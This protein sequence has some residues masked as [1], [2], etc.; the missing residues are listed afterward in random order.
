MV[1]TSTEAATPPAHRLKEY[2]PGAATSHQR[3]SQ[4]PSLKTEAPDYTE[5]IA[6]GRSP[7]HR[8]ENNDHDFLALTF[9]EMATPPVNRLEDHTPVAASLHQRP[10]QSPTRISDSSE[11]MPLLQS[12]SSDD[13]TP[14]GSEDNDKLKKKPENSP[15]TASANASQ[16]CSRTTS[17]TEPSETVPPNDNIFRILPANANSQRKRGRRRTRR[18]AARSISFNDVQDRDQSKETNQFVPLHLNTKE[19]NKSLAQQMNL[20]MTHEQ[21]DRDS[22]AS[23]Y[24]TTT[25]QKFAAFCLHQHSPFAVHNFNSHQSLLGLDYASFLRLTDTLQQASI[26]L[27]G[28]Y[29]QARQDL[30]SSFLHSLAPLLDEAEKTSRAAIVSEFNTRSY[31]PLGPDHISTNR[32][33]LAWIIKSHSRDLPFRIHWREMARLNDDLLDPFKQNDAVLVNLLLIQGLL[34]G[35][36]I[37]QHPAKLHY[38]GWADIDPQSD[39]QE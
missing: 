11:I 21:A 17:D 10:S 39:I 37:S 6:V 3:P 7:V 28:K 29:K 9:T 26:Q 35:P 2:T 18:K 8:D 22:M 1:P 23:N 34:K 24:D 12:S 36:V 32:K 15:V 13:H 19:T 27:A 16:P 14:V 20:T 33:V 30:F 5:C 38:K 4:L 31:K 25:R